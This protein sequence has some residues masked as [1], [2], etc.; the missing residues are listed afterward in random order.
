MIGVVL[1][2]VLISLAEPV[3]AARKGVP[4]R[5]VGG[6]TRLAQPCLDQPNRLTR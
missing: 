5:R 1:S 2:A 6:G 3:W 4:T